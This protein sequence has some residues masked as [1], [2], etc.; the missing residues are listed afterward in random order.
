MAQRGLVDR[1]EPACHPDLCPYILF[2]IQ[3]TSWH[4]GDSY[5]T[6]FNNFYSHS[7]LQIN[8]DFVKISLYRHKCYFCIYLFIYL[9]FI[10]LFI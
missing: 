7:D 6:K 10:Y 1:E 4:L 3:P 8:E 2:P 9:S 5:G